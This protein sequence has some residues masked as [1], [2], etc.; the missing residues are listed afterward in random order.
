MA[1]HHGK[2][3]LIRRWLLAVVLGSAFVVPVHSQSSPASSSP[4]EPRPQAGSDAPQS[5][6]P[7]S[8]EPPDASPQKT[9]EEVRQ[10]QIEEDTKE[11]YALSAEL[12]AEVARTYKES[13]S[14][15]VLKKAEEVEKLARSLKALMN[16]EAA[17]AQEIGSAIEQYSCGTQYHQA[18]GRVEC[19]A[20]NSSLLP[21]SPPPFSCP[22]R[23]PMSR[24]K[25][26]RLDRIDL[27]M[28]ATQVA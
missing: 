14:L 26:S 11:L 2:P 22:R 21:S 17:A 12:R 6:H 7:S 25:T 3:T 15:T 8:A 5:S 24:Q 9:A 1:K 4:S 16:Q 10:A 13:L 23:S 20:L 18:G 19:F 27:T 28:L